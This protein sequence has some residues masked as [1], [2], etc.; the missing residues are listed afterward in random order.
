M[1]GRVLVVKIHLDILKTNLNTDSIFYLLQSQSLHTLE[2]LRP[3]KPCS[4]QGLSKLANGYGL[5]LGTLRP[6]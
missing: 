6:I 3:K 2:A 1:S 5:P 4:F